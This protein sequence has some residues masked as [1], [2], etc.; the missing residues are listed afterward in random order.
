MKPNKSTSSNT[1][2]TR[3]RKPFPMNESIIYPDGRVDVSYEIVIKK[4]VAGHKKGDKLFAGALSKQQVVS[5]LGK[6]KLGIRGH[7]ETVAFAPDSFMGLQY[8]NFVIPEKVMR[9]IDIIQVTKES[10]EV[11]SPVKENQFHDTI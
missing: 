4:A 7:V 2:G 9:C 3:K 10:K 8:V 5:F 6:D 1:K 11:R